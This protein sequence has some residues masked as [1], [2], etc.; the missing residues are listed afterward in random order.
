MKWSFQFRS[1][2]VLLFA[3]FT[4]SIPRA[5]ESVTI[6]ST[7]DAEIREFT[8]TTNVGTEGTMVSGGLGVNVG[9]EA[10]RALLHFDLTGKIPAGA[11]V[12]S[13]KVIL[14]AVKK[15]PTTVS[16]TFALHRLL[17]SWTETGVTWNSRNGQSAWN[18]PGAR[19]DADSAA[20]PSAT[21]VV[22]NLGQYTFGSS[23]GLIEDVNRWLANPESNFGWLLLSQGENT[24]FTARH[25]ATR[26][27]AASRPQLLVE[28][29]MPR[30]DYPKI[31]GI[32]RQNDNVKISFVVEATYVLDL[33]FA[34][35]I[36][37]GPWTTLTNV[38]S[39]MENLPIEFT[40]SILPSAQRFYR[41]KVTGRIR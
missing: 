18:T 25:F 5:A 8:T 14:V 1:L 23:A 2:A 38:S 33:E 35:K 20:T 29:E 13:A 32:T 9:N 40:D 15:P 3:S 17:Q 34:E 11:E 22:S 41:L 7:A 30:A 6:T 19:S 4:A 27:A 37:A 24:P 26:E 31:T 16:S 36:P 39:K 12:I 21:V 10:R 28:Y